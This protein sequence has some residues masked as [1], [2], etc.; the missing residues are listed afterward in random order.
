MQR[1]A[2]LEIS[3]A[4]K[5]LGVLVDTKLN[6]SQ[7]CALAAKKT[8]DILGLCEEQCCQQVEGGDPY[9]LVSTGGVNGGVLC[10]VLGSPVQERDGHRGDS[11]M[12]GRKDDEGTGDEER[13][14]ELGLL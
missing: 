9:T 4:E 2:R 10:P 7:H 14:R 1:A 6:M 8:N 11:P 13:L 5:D 3:F 12:K